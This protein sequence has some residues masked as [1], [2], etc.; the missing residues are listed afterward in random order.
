MKKEEFLTD[1][2]DVLQ[3][4]SNCE[5]NDNLDDYEEWDSLSKMAVMEYFKKKFSIIIPLNELKKIKYV[6]DLLNIAGKNIDD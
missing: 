5:I 6:S 4:E 2:M 3:R 1:L